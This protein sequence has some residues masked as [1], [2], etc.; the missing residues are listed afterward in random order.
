VGRDQLLNKDDV[1]GV[2]CFA[3]VLDDLFHGLK[4]KAYIR[5][6]KRGGAF[7]LPGVNFFP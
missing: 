7:F 6:R 1:I 4:D 5:E 2:E 3:L